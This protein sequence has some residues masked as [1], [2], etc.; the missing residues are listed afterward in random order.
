MEELLNQIE[1]MGFK[2]AVHL[3]GHYP[4]VVPNWRRSST[5]EAG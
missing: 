5:G 2:V 3:S 1:G 4:G